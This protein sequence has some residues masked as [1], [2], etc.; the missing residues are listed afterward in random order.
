MAE[1][2]FEGV[3]KQFDGTLAVDGLDLRIMD[4]ELLVL[5]GPSGC[6]KT[7]ALRMVAGLDDPT[8]GSIRIG[9]RTVNDIPP[10]DRDVAMVF[11]SYALYPHLSVRRNIEFPLRSRHAGAAERQQ[12]VRLAAEMLGLEDLLVRKP[13]HLSGGQRQ[14]VALA[15]ALV[16][17]PQVFLLDEPLSNLDAKLRVRARADIVE[18]QRRLQTTTLYVT[19]DQLEAMTMADR[20]AVINEGRLQQ[21]GPPMEVY[22]APANVFVARFIGSPPMNTLDGVTSNAGKAPVLTVAG[23]FVPLAPPQAIAAG[24]GEGRPLTAGLRPEELSISD[25]GT[26]RAR[27]SLIEPL[28]HLVHVICRLPDQTEL[29]VQQAASQASPGLGQDIGIEVDPERVHLF[30]G[31]DGSRL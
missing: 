6:G 17:Q 21:V 16:R 12:A 8:E 23:G 22:G 10:K 14:R 7:T 11:Q 29:V 1:V 4:H 5:L 18:I 25:S 24:P 3:S 15:R 31:Q 26:I 19:H 20:V 2:V 9:L 30:S 27:V 28:G 13:A